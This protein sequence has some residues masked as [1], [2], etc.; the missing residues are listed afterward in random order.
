M[1][2]VRIVRTKPNLLLG[3]N[4]S[5]SFLSLSLCIHHFTLNRCSSDGVFRLR[6]KN[7]WPFRVNIQLATQRE[8][9]LSEHLPDHCWSLTSNT[10]N[11]SIRTGVVFCAFVA[12]GSW[13]NQ[14]SVTTVLSSSPLYFSL[15]NTLRWKLRINWRRCEASDILA[16]MLSV[17]F[18][19]FDGSTTFLSVPNVTI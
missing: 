17:T 1:S 6:S 9:A 19:I 10:C 13:T 18:Y 3:K 15:F 14:M 12:W 4:L 11:Y 5:I 7:K 8:L 2:R 16:I